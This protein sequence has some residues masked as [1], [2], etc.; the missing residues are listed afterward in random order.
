MLFLTFGENPAY[1]MDRQCLRRF[2]ESVTC[3]QKRAQLCK[4]IPRTYLGE[5]LPTRVFYQS[6]GLPVP[7]LLIVYL[8]PGTFTWMMLSV[9]YDHNLGPFS[10]S[11]IGVCSV[12]KIGVFFFRLTYGHFMHQIF[13]IDLIALFL[14][15]GIKK[16]GV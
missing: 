1:D 3:V 11:K 5:V 8:V 15:F 16:F 2:L 14:G 12:Y 7:H 4:I 10:C 9:V 6:V 13:L